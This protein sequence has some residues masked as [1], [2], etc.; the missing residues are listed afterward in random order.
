MS[1]SYKE[2]NEDRETR[3]TMK[4]RKVLRERLRDFSLLIYRFLLV[5][6]YGNDKS[7]AAT[8]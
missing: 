6:Q 1:I 8:L 2:V 5:D 4:R 7:M 3:V